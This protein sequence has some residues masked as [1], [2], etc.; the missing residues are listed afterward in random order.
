MR[1]MDGVS[2]FMLAQEKPGSYMHTLKI[3]ILDI[4]ELD[5]GWSFDHFRT[6]LAR[7]IPVMPMLRWKVKKVPFGLHHPVCV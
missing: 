3:S 5:G 4:S 6:S 1:R 7:R 2:A